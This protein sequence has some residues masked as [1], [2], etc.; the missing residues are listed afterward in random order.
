MYTV[1]VLCSKSFNTVYIGFTSDIE[2]RLI[3]HNHPKNK[4]W[5]RK[6]QPW[7]LAY[8]EP[9]D[10]KITAMAREKQLKTHLG[11]NSAREKVKEYLLKSG[12]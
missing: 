10:S 4:G 12:A 9:F 6:F 11:R 2:Q 1:Y 7:L 3:A 8:S 5:T